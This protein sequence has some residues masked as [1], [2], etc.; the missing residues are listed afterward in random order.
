MIVEISIILGALIA[1]AAGIQH[2]W[3]RYADRGLYQR[4]L[5]QAGDIRSELAGLNVTI[6][7]AIHDEFAA[8]AIPEFPDIRPTFTLL[9][10][11]IEAFPALM[12]E[13]VRQGLSSIG[14]SVAGQLSGI[15]RQEKAQGHAMSTEVEGFA[16]I[17]AKKLAL[18][19]AGGFHPAAGAALSIANAMGVIDDATLEKFAEILIDNPELMGRLNAA[20]QRIQA[21]RGVLPEGNGGGYRP[22]IG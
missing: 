2:F 11:A 13:G 6:P 15:A 18:A 12:E 21:G 1:G 10:E 8:L 20:G 14:G 5:R 3:D 19:A 4:S 17:G 9:H 16:K 22:G 7:K